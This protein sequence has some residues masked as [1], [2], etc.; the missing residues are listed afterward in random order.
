MINNWLLT[1]ALKMKTADQLAGVMVA[2]VTTT[3]SVYA[4]IVQSVKFT[5]PHSPLHFLEA[6]V[7]DRKLLCSSEHLMNVVVSSLWSFHISPWDI[8]DGQATRIKIAEYNF[9]AALSFCLAHHF[10]KVTITLLLLKCYTE[11][12]IL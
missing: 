6:Y 2:C 5:F 8:F 7:P 1:D 4:C 11:L 12:S 9:S 10:S 3:G